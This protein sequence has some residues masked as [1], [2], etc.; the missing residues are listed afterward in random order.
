MSTNKGKGP[1]SKEQLTPEAAAAALMDGEEDEDAIDRMFDAYRRGEIP[2]VPGY[3]RDDHIEEDL[4]NTPLFMSRAPQGD[5]D[6][7][8]VPN[9]LRFCFFDTFA[10]C[11][12]L[13]CLRSHRRLLLSRALLT[14][15]RH[16][17]RLPLTSRTA[18]TK[19]FDRVAKRI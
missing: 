16:P 19:S 8:K 18:V 15:N 11:V 9:L 2:R 12:F 7:E 17:R 6:P 1:A 10:C 14:K 4:E 13:H 3:I 5:V